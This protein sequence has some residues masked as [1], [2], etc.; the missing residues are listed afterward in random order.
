M[1][2]TKQFLD[3]LLANL[4]DVLKLD[5]AAVVDRDGLIITSVMSEAGDDSEREFQVGKFTAL[6]DTFVDRIKH[7]LGAKPQFYTST[8]VGTQK[9]I[10]TSAGP[11]A[12]LTV[13]A[14]EK[15]DDSKIR[16]LATEAGKRVEQ[17]IAGDKTVSLVLPR[18]SDL[19]SVSEIDASNLTPDNIFD[20]LFGAIDTM[21]RKLFGEGGPSV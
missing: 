5:G 9:F 18:I 6:A 3:K 19:V 12:I 16:A 11:E 15:Q 7:E 20:G 1:S 8:T 2:E 10:F 13:I 17:I 14:D 21:K 4:I